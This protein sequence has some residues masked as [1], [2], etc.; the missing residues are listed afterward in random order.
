MLDRKQPCS[1]GAGV[2]SSVLSDPTAG[3]GWDQPPSASGSPQVVFIPHTPPPQHL[4]CTFPSSEPRGSEPRASFPGR[5]PEIR[6]PAH[7]SRPPWASPVRHSLTLLPEASPLQGRD[8]PLAPD[9]LW[10]IPAI[11]PPKPPLSRD[12]MPPP[13][14]GCCADWLGLSTLASVAAELS[15]GGGASEL[16]QG[17]SPT[18]SPA[19]HT[20]ISEHPQS[21]TARGREPRPGFEPRA[22]CLSAGPCCSLAWS[23]S[24]HPHTPMGRGLGSL[25]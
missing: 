24:I 16:T 4:I 13:P 8:T 3:L 1:C 12:S 19:S 20:L 10:R 2:L 15:P 25:R 22:R 18:A 9:K 23:P 11:S 6:G 5:S 7:R 14:R 17:S 21:P